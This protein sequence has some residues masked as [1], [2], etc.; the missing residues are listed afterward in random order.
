MT[1]FE[2]RMAVLFRDISYKDWKFHI[3]QDAV[4]LHF[5][6]IRFTA[7]DAQSG[8]HQAWNGRKWRLSTHMTDSEIVQTALKAVLSAEEHEAREGF[9]FRGRAIFGPHINIEHLWHLV[10]KPDVLETRTAADQE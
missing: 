6:Q 8:A 3:G 2:T 10:G 5:L 9:R 7:F 1:T 4:G